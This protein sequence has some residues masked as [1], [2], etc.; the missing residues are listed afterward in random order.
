MKKRLL[1]I[2]LVLILLAVVI[3][4]QSLTVLSTALLIGA[5]AF[6]FIKREDSAEKQKLPWQSLVLAGLSLALY[7]IDWLVLG[8]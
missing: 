3:Y 7:L 4:F 5:A 8:H 1:T 2:G 6:A